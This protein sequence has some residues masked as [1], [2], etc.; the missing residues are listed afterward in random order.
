ME[1]IFEW[2]FPS[3]F[4]SDSWMEAD[5]CAVCV[6][7]AEKWRFILKDFITKPPIRW[8]FRYNPCCAM[9]HIF[10]PNWMLIFRC[11]HKIDAKG[12]WFVDVVCAFKVVT[13]NKII[14]CFEWFRNYWCVMLHHFSGNEKNKAAFHLGLLLNF[15]HSPNF[16]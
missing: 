6:K 4:I 11:A 14:A 16:E 10:S 9:F 15:W 12:I 1:N 5:K 13:H 8:L 2:E 7:S 3:D